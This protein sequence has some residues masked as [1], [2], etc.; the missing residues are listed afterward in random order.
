MTNIYTWLS[1]RAHFIFLMF[2]VPATFAFIQ[3]TPPA[4]GLDEQVHIARAYQISEGRLYPDPIGEKGSY[5]GYLPASLV[6]NINYGHQ[7]SNSV[8][9][10]APFYARQDVKSKFELSVIK[11]EKINSKK[12][13]QYEFGPAGAYSPVVYAPA[14]FGMALGTWFDLSVDNTLKLAKSMQASLYLLFVFIGLL[15]LRNNKSEWLI[16]IIALLPSTIFLSATINADS[17]TIGALILFIASLLSVLS[18]KKIMNNKQLIV[19]GLVTALLM[20]S[21]PS[22][23]IFALA[24]FLLPVN[25]FG[26]VKRKW[27]TLSAILSVASVVFLA[28]TIKGLMYSSSI[29]LYKESVAAQ[30]NLLD[31]IKWTAL[32][33]LDFAI[34]VSKTLLAGGYEWGQSTIGL[35]G[36]NTIATPY[37]FMLLISIVLAIAALYG[38][39]QY[40]KSEA[41]AFLALGTASAFSVILIVYGTFNT[42]GNPEIGG[43]QGRYFIPCLPFLLLGIARLMPIKTSIDSHFVAPFFATSSALV[44]YVTIGVYFVALF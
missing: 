2:A 22:Y 23:N 38:A 28:S 7:Q 5:G 25:L 32:H 36:Y 8:N 19:I 34:S 43:V 30:I 24:L 6:K 21:K 42:V 13:L 9:R 40:K 44:L 29:S 26:S 41:L 20:T 37:I 4:W 31:Q 1:L 33:P 15:L 12:K 3:I 16:F 17:F 18:Q 35:L 11:N 14:A 39:K 10:A 27:L